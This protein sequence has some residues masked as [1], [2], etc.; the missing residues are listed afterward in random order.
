MTGIELTIIIGVAF[1][2]FALERVYASTRQTETI[3]C[4]RT[5][6]RLLQD[7]RDDARKR[8]VEIVQELAEL[9]GNF[10]NYL[11]G[12]GNDLSKI[13]MALHGDYDDPVRK[14]LNPLSRIEDYLSS[15]DNRVADI[16]LALESDTEGAT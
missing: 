11:A 4:L 14:T 6:A 9:S 5:M 15:I 3:E 2:L 16:N 7:I 12:I 13:D 1:I 10:E 8:N